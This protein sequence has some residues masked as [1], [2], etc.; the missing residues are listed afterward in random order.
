[1]LLLERFSERQ[2]LQ[3]YTYAVNCLKVVFLIASTRLLFEPLLEFSKSN[4]VYTR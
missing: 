4:V 3:W 2:A 1:V